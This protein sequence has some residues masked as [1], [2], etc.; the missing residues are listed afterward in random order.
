M[1]EQTLHKMHSK[2]SEWCN[3]QIMTYLCLQ[4]WL[5]YC[6]YLLWVYIGT[7]QLELLKKL[8]LHLII[9][10]IIAIKKRPKILFKDLISHLCTFCSRER[11]SE[12]MLRILSAR[13]FTLKRIDP[14]RK[15]KFHCFYSRER[16]SGTGL[17]IFSKK[18]PFSPHHR[19]KADAPSQR[20]GGTVFLTTQKLN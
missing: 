15:W 10:S 3:F 12:E 8:K 9:C 18:K 19:E 20:K 16:L 6:Y 1:T 2:Y 4:I 7:F 17:H 13:K 5:S 14:R 11:I